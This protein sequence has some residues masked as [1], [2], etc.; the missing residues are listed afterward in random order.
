MGQ[1]SSATLI[2]PCQGPRAEHQLMLLPRSP[3][4]QEVCGRSI[5]VLLLGKRGFACMKSS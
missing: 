5:V 3:E 4:Q 2:L 1:A